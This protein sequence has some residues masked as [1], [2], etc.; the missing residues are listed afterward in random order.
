MK[1]ALFTIA[2]L[3][4]QLEVAGQLI[5]PGAPKTKIDEFQNRS[6]ALI[7]KEYI[8]VAGTRTVNI[9]VVK[10]TLMPEKK[11]A[12]SGVL[13]SWGSTSIGIFQQTG[14]AYLDADEIDSVIKGID[15]MGKMIAG[16]IPNNYTELELSTRTG[17]K[18]TLFPSKTAWNIALECQGHR[19]Y[20]YQEDLAKIQESLLSAKSK[21]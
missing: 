2:L 20:I 16:T 19:Q 14:Q 18:L 8:D 21:L 15:A 17:F 5:D 7:L 1:H 10:M 11:E 12:I 3:A 4:I 6:G 9:Q 13:I